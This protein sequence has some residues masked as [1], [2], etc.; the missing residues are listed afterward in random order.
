[1]DLFVSFDGDHIGRK[2]GQLSLADDE[3]GVRR[4][5]QAIDSGNRLVAAWVNSV[6]GAMISYGGDELRARIPANS[7]VDVER[8]RQQYATAVGSSVSVGV[9]IRLSEAD[10]ALLSAKIR[11]GDQVMLYGPDVDKDLV[12]LQERSE[13]QKLGDEYLIKA[14]KIGQAA[15]R[16]KINGSIVPSGAIHDPE[17]LPGGENSSDCYEPGFIDKSGRFYSED[18]VKDLEGRL[19]KDDESAGPKIKEAPTNNASAGGGYTPIHEAG[20]GGE[21]QPP[22]QE[23]SEHSQGEAM[24]AMADETSSPEGSGAAA[25]FESELHDHAKEQDGQDQADEDAKNG[26]ADARQKVLE[27]LSQVRQA[28]PQ[29]EQLRDQ[30]PDLYA[31]L[32]QMTQALV[33]TSRG[34]LDD[35]GQSDSEK[36][37]EQ[38]GQEQSSPEQSGSPAQ[39]SEKEAPPGF[40][41]ETMKKL[42][43]KH[44]DWLAHKIAWAAH[45]KLK[46]AFPHNPKV[47]VISPTHELSMKYKNAAKTPHEIQR[48]MVNHDPLPTGAESVYLAN[49]PRKGTPIA[50]AVPH[51]RQPNK[52]QQAMATAHQAASSEDKVM[53]D[54]AFESGFA[55]ET[56]PPIAPVPRPRVGEFPEG[57]NSQRTED[58]ITEAQRHNDNVS[59]AQGI[60]RYKGTATPAPAA[61]DRDPV[62]DSK[63]WASKAQS[64]QKINQRN[65]RDYWK[66]IDRASRPPIPPYQ[67]I[68]SQGPD[69]QPMSFEW[70]MT[71]PEPNIWAIGANGRNAM[72]QLRAPNPVHEIDPATGQARVQDLSDYHVWP[73]Y[74]RGDG[75]QDGYSRAVLDHLHNFFMKNPLAKAAEKEEDLDKMQSHVNLPVGATKDGKVK[76]R[77]GEDGKTGWVSVRA[78]QVLSN[79]GHAVSSRNPGGR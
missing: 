5:S 73:A 34:L 13:S 19:K 55:P 4:I 77:H 52:T 62:K 18:Q 51:N 27:I 70:D 58:R 29:L 42:K 35:Q 38:Q 61:W 25:N 30:A 11:G 46:K 72:Y 43:A 22:M 47:P 67:P 8:I 64:T 23:G 49:A 14:E 76:V 59:Y 24:M 7:L 15:F 63:I 39:K 78:G 44:G 79:D 40:N 6:L 33:I 45:G 2:V 17:V 56:P 32:M 28:A 36:V 21:P 3:E 10:K 60:D 54:A 37:V 12:Q 75:T 71:R 68:T 65:D 50:T 31:V 48:Q 41:E 53:M 20:T 16:H 74:S 26:R 66:G 57:P 1:M 9:G 69:S